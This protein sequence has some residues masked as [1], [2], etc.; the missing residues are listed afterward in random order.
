MFNNLSVAA[1]LLTLLYWIEKENTPTPFMPPLP[2]RP[3]LMEFCHSI[4]GVTVS[5]CLTVALLS[6]VILTGSAG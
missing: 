5:Y 2:P 6:M 3:T 4:T 1:G